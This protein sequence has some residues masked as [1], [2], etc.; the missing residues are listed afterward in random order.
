MTAKI[1]VAELFNYLSK[2]PRNTVHVLNALMHSTHSV[3]P[4]CLW[5]TSMDWANCSSVLS[6]GRWFNLSSPE[7]P[8]TVST[9]QKFPCPQGS[10]VLRA[11]QKHLA[12]MW[13]PRANNSV[14][15]RDS[16]PTDLDMFRG[17]RTHPKYA[18]P[19]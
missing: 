5:W 15:T 14:N 2:I 8:S 9:S 7:Q 13:R 16:V 1:L 6:M 10:S 3:G 11:D 12:F 4:V 17:P 18:S 19:H